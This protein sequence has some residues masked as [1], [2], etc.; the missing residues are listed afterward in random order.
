MSFHYLASPY[1]SQ[2]AAFMQ[3]RFEAVEQMT[4]RLLKD[5]I[6]VYSPI[7]H[8]HELANKFNLP[9][10]FEYWESYNS[11]LLAKASQLLVLD[12][13]GWDESRGVCKEI[14]LASQLSIPVAFLSD[15]G[16][17]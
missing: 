6:W 4:A 1:T 12:I 11:A 17:L 7:V 8:C 5:S 15:L 16:Y 10:N 13:E 14:E 2:E 3:R 9:R